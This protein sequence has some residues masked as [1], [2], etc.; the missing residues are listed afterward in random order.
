[1][2]QLSQLE[3]LMQVV[4]FCKYCG[5]EFPDRPHLPT[6]C[7]QCGRTLREFDKPV[8]DSRPAKTAASKRADAE[9]PRKAK[10]LKWLW[11]K[12]RKK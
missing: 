12:R 6:K 8:I 11:P 7:P 10:R 2:H 3:R 4:Y 1:M 9:K 5:Y